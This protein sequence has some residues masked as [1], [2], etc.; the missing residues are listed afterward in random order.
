MSQTASGHA[1]SSGASELHSLIALQDTSSEEESDESDSQ[2]IDDEFTSM[3]SPLVSPA[4]KQASTEVPTDVAAPRPAHVVAAQTLDFPEVM[5]DSSGA[6]SDSSEAAPV[7]TRAE[8]AQP[9]HESDSFDSSSGSE[10]D[11]FHDAEED[12]MHRKDREESAATKELGPGMGTDALTSLLRKHS[13]REAELETLVSEVADEV[14]DAARAKRSGG[15]P[16]V[17][18]EELAFLQVALDTEEDDESDVGSGS[19]DSPNDAVGDDSSVHGTSGDTSSL[20]ARHHEESDGSGSDDSSTSSD[21]FEDAE[22]GPVPAPSASDSKDPNQPVL[23][24]SPLE[25]IKRAF[26]THYVTMVKAQEKLLSGLQSPSGRSL[27]QKEA[28]ARN[29]DE[30]EVVEGFVR[31]L[32]SGIRDKIKADTGIDVFDERYQHG[33]QAFQAAAAVASTRREDIEGTANRDVAHGTSPRAS[34]V[35]RAS[36]KQNPDKKLQP[37]LSPVQSWKQRIHD[38]KE[39]NRHRSSLAVAGRSLA[40]TTDHEITQTRIW[41][42]RQLVRLRVAMMLNY[43]DEA[44]VLALVKWIQARFRLRAMLRLKAEQMRKRSRLENRWLSGLSSGSSTDLRNKT[45][46]ERRVRKKQARKRLRTAINEATRTRDVDIL[47]IQLQVAQRDLKSGDKIVVEAHALVDEIYEEREKAEQ[48]LKR[49][50]EAEEEAKRRAEEAKAEADAKRRAEAEAEAEA[51][52]RRRAQAEAETR[53]QAEA[54][55]EAKRRAEAEA[56]AK[57]RAEAEAEARRQAEAEAEAKRRAE[58]EAEAKRRAEAEADAAQRR[59]EAQAEAARQA[60]EDDRMAAA[61]ELAMAAQAAAEADEQRAAADAEQQRLLALVAE[62]ESEKEALAKERADLEAAQLAREAEKKRASEIAAAEEAEM[63]AQILAEDKARRLA[64]EDAEKQRQEQENARLAALRSEADAEKKRV[65]ELKATAARLAAEKQTKAKRKAAADA[66]IAAL[67]AEVSRIATT[68]RVT[69]EEELAEAAAV[70]AAEQRKKANTKAT[71]R[72]A[73]AFIAAAER[74]REAELAAHVQLEDE[75]ALAARRKAQEEQVAALKQEAKQLQQ[76]AEEAR[77]AVLQ[78]RQQQR[79]AEADFLVAEAARSAEKKDRHESLDDAHNDDDADD[80]SVGDVADSSEPST[81]EHD[82]SVPGDGDTQSSPKPSQNGRATEPQSLQALRHTPSR[83]HRR[84][85]EPHHSPATAILPRLRDDQSRDSAHSSHDRSPAWNNTGS[86]T[87]SP[88]PAWLSPAGMSPSV[89]PPHPVRGKSPRAPTSLSGPQKPERL[90]PRSSQRARH[91]STA[92][93]GDDHRLWKRLPSSA[94]QSPRTSNASSPTHSPTA[95]DPDLAA[96]FI[97]ELLCRHSAFTEPLYN[98]L[99]HFMKENLNGKDGENRQQSVFDSIV[100]MFP[101]D[102]PIRL[103]RS[104]QQAIEQRL[105]SG[106]KEPSSAI[107]NHS[108][109]PEVPGPASQQQ[110]PSPSTSASV[111]LAND[112]SPAYLTNISRALQQFRHNPHPT[113]RVVQS[114]TPHSPEP[115]NVVRRI[116]RYSA[117]IPIDLD[118]L[119][120]VSAGAAGLAVASCHLDVVA[121]ATGDAIERGFPTLTDIE[122][123]PQHRPTIIVTAVSPRIARYGISPGDLVLFVE[124]CSIS[125][126]NDFEI[127]LQAAIYRSWAVDEEQDGAAVG[128][129]AA[130]VSIVFARLYG[131]GKLIASDELYTAN[132]HASADPA[133]SVLPANISES[134]PARLESH[135]QK[136]QSML[137]RRLQRQRRRRKYDEEDA[138]RNDNSTDSDEDKSIRS[139]TSRPKADDHNTTMFPASVVIMDAGDSGDDDDLS[140]VHRIVDALQHKEEST[141]SRNHHKVEIASAESQSSAAATADALDES[142][143]DDII[144][145]DI[146]P[147]AESD[148][149]IVLEACERLVRLIAPVV[150]NIRLHRVRRPRRAGNNFLLNRGFESPRQFFQWLT[151]VSNSFLRVDQLTDADTKGPIQYVLFPEQSPPSRVRELVVALRR[152]LEGTFVSSRPGDSASRLDMQ[153]DFHSWTQECRDRVGDGMLQRIGDALGSRF[154][155]G[156]GAADVENFFVRS[157]PTLF[158]D[159]LRDALEALESRRADLLWNGVDPPLGPGPT[160]AGSDIGRDSGPSAHRAKVNSSSNSSDDEA[161]TAGETADDLDSSHSDDADLDAQRNTAGYIAR[162]F[163]DSAGSGRLAI[164]PKR[165]PSPVREADIDARIALLLEEKLSKYGLPLLQSFAQEKSDIAK[166]HVSNRAGEENRDSPSEHRSTA[167]RLPGAQFI[168][169][170]MASQRE[171]RPFRKDTATPSSTDHTFSLHAVDTAPPDIGVVEADDQDLSVAPREWAEEEVRK[172]LLEVQGS[173]RPAEH[174]LRA[175]ERGRADANNWK[176]TVLRPATLQARQQAVNDALNRRQ[177]WPHHSSSTVSVGVSSPPTEVSWTNA[178]T[179]AIA[180]DAAARGLDFRHSVASAVLRLPDDLRSGTD[181]NLSNAEA[182]FVALDRDGDGVISQSEFLGVPAA[183]TNSG[184]RHSAPVESTKAIATTTAEPSPWDEVK[185]I[186]ASMFDAIAQYSN[187]AQTADNV[188]PV[189]SVSSAG[190]DPI[191]ESSELQKI[192]EAT[193]WDE[194]R[195]LNQS[196]TESIADFAS[197]KASPGNE[198]RY[199]DLQTAESNDAPATAHDNVHQKSNASPPTKQQSQS[200]LNQEAAFAALDS[201]GDGVVSKQEFLAAVANL[202]SSVLASANAEAS[203]AVAAAQKAADVATAAA[204][205]AVALAAAMAAN[206]VNFNGAPNTLQQFNSASTT[207]SPDSG[208]SAWQHLKAKTTSMLGAVESLSFSAN[209]PIGAAIASLSDEDDDNEFESLAR[210]RP[211]FGSAYKAPLPPSPWRTGTSDASAAA[212]A[213]VAEITSENLEETFGSRDHEIE[214][215]PEPDSD[216]EIVERA[217]AVVEDHHSP[218]DDDESVLDATSISSAQDDSDDESS[219]TE[220]LI[221][222]LSSPRFDPAARRFSTAGRSSAGGGGA[223]RQGDN[224]RATRRHGNGGHNPTASMV[225]AIDGVVPDPN[226][227]PGIDLIKRMEP[228]LLYGDS[229]PPVMDDEFK[230]KLTPPH[231]ID[232]GERMSISNDSESDVTPTAATSAKKGIRSQ[233]SFASA[234]ERPV[235]NPNIR[236]AASVLDFDRE[237]KQFTIMSPTEGIVKTSKLHFSPD[238]IE[239]VRERLGEPDALLK[240][241]EAEI[242][243]EQL[244]AQREHEEATRRENELKM[245]EKATDV[246]ALLET[247]MRAAKEARKDAK[248]SSTSEDDLYQSSSED[249]AAQQD[250][251]D[252]AGSEVLDDD[253][254]SETGQQ[255]NKLFYV[256]DEVDLLWDEDAATGQRTYQPGEVM[257][258]GGIPRVYSVAMTTMLGLVLDDVEAS[259]LCRRGQGKA[260]AKASRDAAN[261]SRA[262]LTPLPEEVSRPELDSMAE[263]A[264]LDDIPRCEGYLEKKATTGLR[265]PWQKRF[266]VA[267]DG[268]VSYWKTDKRTGD[269]TVIPLE[270]AEIEVFAMRGTEFA[271]VTPEK[272]YRLRAKTNADMKRWVDFIDGVKKAGKSPRGKPPKQTMSTKP[273]WAQKPAHSSPKQSPASKSGGSKPTTLYLPMTARGSTIPLFEAKGRGSYMCTAT[274]G[275]GFRRTPNFDDKYRDIP[276]PVE[277]EVF[278]ASGPTVRGSENILFIP[279]DLSTRQEITLDEPDTESD[280]EADQS[281][282]EPEVGSAGGPNV[283]VAEPSG[284]KTTADADSKADS[285]ASAEEQSDADAGSESDSESRRSD[286]DTESPASGGDD[287]SDA[288]SAGSTPASRDASPAGFESPAAV[289]P[290]E[291]KSD[292]PPPTQSLHAR[293]KSWTKPGPLS[294]K[295]GGA[296]R[297]NAVKDVASAAARVVTPGSHAPALVRRRM[298]SLCL[299]CRFVAEHMICGARL[300]ALPQ[301]HQLPG[302]QQQR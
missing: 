69:A 221:A 14:M 270:E 48:E 66:R 199:H 234:L 130:S 295:L 158:E 141:A 77:L 268:A 53:R 198:L 139:L 25:R 153:R 167:E 235:T 293:T 62:V 154:C 5:T 242:R 294:L 47:V 164:P 8:T 122:R 4:K 118:T 114:A 287:S 115:Q 260:K 236:H 230:G 220:E 97:A 132:S 256:G 40:A 171:S 257:K 177:Q 112:N 279:V 232:G 175:T 216:E 20:L 111:D 44:K 210:G 63:R 159:L 140:D 231:V 243:E 74:R 239:A 121:D 240:K 52:A 16:T 90:P 55:A 45:K 113:A 281:A 94:Q 162:E 105:Q 183:S 42:R 261:L 191:E 68:R 185:Q 298:P 123:S 73:E 264:R 166:D 269:A 91:S 289:L 292:L 178:T 249:E 244:K 163:T 96:G 110:S 233:P 148:A 266:F 213:L 43:P 29:V 147:R 229:L 155:S 31:K 39:E 285:E 223:E 10:S 71:M 15:E 107:G 3:S 60:A 82:N 133:N 136:S 101:P 89:S 241:S 173:A 226:K 38:Q 160:S 26:P 98:K 219:D 76:E 27:L 61:S 176:A 188:V 145:G 168:A 208:S 252:K 218:A 6:E 32:Q 217:T 237:T 254:G 88:V 109:S 282:L 172:A 286:S 2:L 297:I 157:D 24:T 79:Q 65:L 35:R 215:Q 119:E 17:N 116:S 197:S 22:T 120:T 99:S 84:A 278:V 194:L 201:N 271:I 250:P 204:K 247:A 92:R 125:S 56:E 70:E 253:A 200:T 182:A 245:M 144:V 131:R 272:R 169:E 93:L 284:D 302:P 58:A 265:H 64:A 49:R 138:F 273:D 238:K 108:S 151:S 170:L 283:G 291:E 206:S 255:G 103:V 102:T 134:Y 117:H 196:M 187:E 146:V 212:K 152:S 228:N 104:V 274:T 149:E 209:S 21:A 301:R 33:G 41:E 258:A 189:E 251:G 1:G 50:A 11:A 165:S 128:S 46:I 86:P 37:T 75:E 57:R 227:K 143:G 129:N 23:P 275:V 214:E 13:H 259:R 127:A 30:G 7:V 36:L 299:F 34:T 72:V 54:E 288:S 277:F 156:A 135:F 124:G 222:T 207:A 224:A 161:Y 9:D 263:A 184:A 192:S 80:E 205:E 262:Q 51:E 276:G 83:P 193:P 67:Q 137:R 12:D 202:G 186:N 81:G 246:D 180:A 300:L 19:Q 28:E 106:N 85:H 290:G 211:P 190:I 179:D 95:G 203:T 150:K 181:G 100:D 59:A 195:K 225:M 126:E 174:N 248:A 78:A 296:G 280:S 267:D 142:K 18:P 87:S